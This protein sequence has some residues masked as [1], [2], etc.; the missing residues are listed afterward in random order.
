MLK[1]SWLRLAPEQEEVM[2][3]AGTLSPRALDLLRA[4]EVMARYGALVSTASCAARAGDGGP[5]KT[6]PDASSWRTHKSI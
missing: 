5:A 6:P 2:R 3:R 4:D 1:H